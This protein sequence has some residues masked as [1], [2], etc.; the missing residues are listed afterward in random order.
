MAK[1]I[2]IISK[3]HGKGAQTHFRSSGRI[4]Y[5]T[6]WSPMSILSLEKSLLVICKM[7]WLFLNTLS[8]SDKYSQF[9]KDNFT[10]EIQMHISQKQRTFSQ[11]FAAV[12]KS[13]LNLEHFQKKVNPHS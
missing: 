10:Q 3:Q 1:Q 12:L 13:R 2:S 8:A 7:L 11:I 5:H 6:Y 9:N 4:L